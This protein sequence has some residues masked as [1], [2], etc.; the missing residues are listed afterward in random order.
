MQFNPMT[1]SDVMWDH[2]LVNTASGNGLTP[3]GTKQLPQPMFD[4]NQ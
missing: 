4:F 3:D 1:P 2:Q